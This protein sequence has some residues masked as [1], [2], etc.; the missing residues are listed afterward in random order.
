MALAGKNRLLGF[1]QFTQ[2][3]RSGLKRQCGPAPF[4]LIRSTN[5]HVNGARPKLAR[6]LDSATRSIV[7]GEVLQTLAFVELIGRAETVW[8]SADPKMI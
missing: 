5:H 3:R 8:K 4:F 2:D 1:A 6:N 7:D